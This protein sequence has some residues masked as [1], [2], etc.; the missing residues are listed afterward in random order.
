[1]TAT[2]QTQTRN[3]VVTKSNH[4][5]EASY[6]LNLDEQRLMLS[7]IG[8]VEPH[9][10]LPA[11]FTVTAEDFANLFRLNK[12][13]A[14]E[15][16]RRAAMSLVGKTVHTYDKQALIGEK[17]VWVDHVKYYDGEGYVEASFSAWI[18]PYIYRLANQFTSYRIAALSQVKS[19]YAIRLF[20][21][22]MQ[23]RESGER[24]ITLNKFREMLQLETKYSRFV[25]MKNKI[26]NPSV[27]EINQKTDY[28]VGW[29]TIKKRRA[30]VTLIFHFE[31]A[32]QTKM[33]FD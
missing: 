4:L 30:V 10:P 26:I 14:Y 21:L 8:Q 12:K 19:V 13:N 9:K 20:E 5:I 29:E 18:K 1:M 23:F 15:Q 2:K 28:F 24:Y 16:L 6:R 3:L 31:L 11:L 25:D 17:T 32:E 33:L 27:E 22:L 7:L